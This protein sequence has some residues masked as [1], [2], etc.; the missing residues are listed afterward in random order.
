MHP[1]RGDERFARPTIYVV[2]KDFTHRQESVF[3]ERPGHAASNQQP[4]IVFHQAFTSLL[5]D[6]M[7][8]SMNKVDILKNK[9]SSA[10]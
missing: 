5:I 9:C 10:C 2:R 3:E 8:A 6:G 4:A 7:K 1:V